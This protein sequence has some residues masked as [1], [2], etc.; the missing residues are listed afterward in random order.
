MSLIDNTLRDPDIVAFLQEQAGIIAEAQ[1][2]A[3]ALNAEMAALMDAGGMHNIRKAKRL[4]VEVKAL[5]AKINLARDKIQKARDIEAERDRRMGEARDPLIW[6]KI[7]GEQVSVQLVEKAEIAR[8][9]HGAKIINRAGPNRGLAALVYEHGATVG[10]KCG[11][12]HAFAT[13]H[14]DN[15]RT[16]RGGEALL[17]FGK[18]YEEQF[19]KVEPLK[20]VNPEA[21]GGG[22][23]G[24]RG[25]Q[26]GVCEASEWLKLAH[27]GLNGRQA[28]ALTHICGMGWTISD[29]RTHKSWGFDA[30]ARALRSGLALAAANIA[31]ARENAGDERENKRFKVAAQMH[32]ARKLERTG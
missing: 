9:Q 5:E 27:M 22:G 25:P 13:G 3:D 15:P 28:A 14:L 21:V 29:L 20:A 32:A 7:R 31:E 19:A 26:Q 1:G 17:H 18:F 2:S 4:K 6:R 16:K 10:I 11:V 8:D 30:T 24:P 12:G 23:A